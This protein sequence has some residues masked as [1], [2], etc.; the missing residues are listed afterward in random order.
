MVCDFT[1][2]ASDIHHVLYYIRIIGYDSD[3]TNFN[4]SLLIPHS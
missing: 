4:S 3:L 2:F 1:G